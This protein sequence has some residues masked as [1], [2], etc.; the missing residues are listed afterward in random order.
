MGDRSLRSDMELLASWGLIDGTLTTWPIP[1]AELD[2]FASAPNLSDEPVFVQLA[3]KRVLDAAHGEA[4]RAMSRGNVGARAT[5]YTDVVRDFGVS[6]R[7]KVSG[8]VGGTWTTSNFGGSLQVSSEP[9]DNNNS[10]QIGLDGSYFNFLVEGMQVYGG[11]VDKWYG[12]GW[13]SSLAL[14]NNARPIPKIGLQRNNPT[15]FDISWAPWLSWIG[16]WQFDTFIGLLDG[17]RHDAN[18]LLAGFRVS[19]KPAKFLEI[20]LGRTSEL[21]GSNHGCSPLKDELEFN[22]QSNHPD[23]VNDEASIDIKYHLM[24]QGVEVTPYAQIMNESDGPFTHVGASYLAG[25]SLAGPFGDSGAQYRFTVEYADSVA[26]VNLFDFGSKAYTAAYNSSKYPDGM[27]YKGRSLG[28]SLDSDSRLLSVTT[29]V[30]DS[31]NRTYRLALYRAAIN[32][33]PPQFVSF[34]VVSP[35]PVTISEIELGATSETIF[36][37]TA[38]ATIRQQSARVYPGGGG[39]TSAELGLTYRFW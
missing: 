10:T 1:N 30:I 14:S 17:P 35:E 31:F 15:P 16:P 7:E 19:F 29:S 22:N 13:V 12:P 32:H 21:C 4:A 36:G 26:T 37:F 25:T 28:F 39:K 33:A 11:W 23:S 38:D 34:N 9:Q 8:V 2:Q 5:N 6:A 18:T 27:R 24:L 20:G 3:A